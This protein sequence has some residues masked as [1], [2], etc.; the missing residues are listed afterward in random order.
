MISSTP[1]ST[2]PPADWQAVSFHDVQ[3]QTPG[4]WRILD[5]NQTGFCG[6]PFPTNATVFLGPQRNVVP[7]CAPPPPG[8]VQP[9]LDGVWL[10]PGDPPSDA[11]PITTGSGETVLRQPASWQTSNSSPVTDYWYHGVQ[12]VLGSGP[13]PAV[14]KR[15]LD[16]VRYQSGVPDTPAAESCGLNPQPDAMPT[17]ERLSQRMV[18]DQ[19]NITFDPPAPSDQ[20]T[21]KPEAAWQPADKPGF[22][23]SP[24]STYRIILARYSGRYPATLNPDGSTTP[25]N[26]NLLAWVV[27]SAP[28]TPDVPRCGG[29]GADIFDA[30]TGQELIAN[31][32]ATSP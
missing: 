4:S 15:I 18:L 17:P 21:M 27:Y 7:P 32:W 14:A 23:H 12:I 10:Q 2:A 29:W 9:P 6:G 3:I 22:S 1:G 24:L 30:R 13:D 28:V 8:R 26:Q 16:S 11:E 31:G 5:G 20:P 25:T 19:G